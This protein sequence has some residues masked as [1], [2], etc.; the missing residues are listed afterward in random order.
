MKSDPWQWLKT[1]PGLFAAPRPEP[2]RQAERIVAVQRRIVLP[3][4]VGV[5]AVALYSVF[6]YDWLTGLPTFIWQ[7]LRGF[8]QFYVVCNAIA[9]VVFFTWR[10]F[11]PELFQCL[12]FAL[13]ILDG[14]FIAGLMLIPQGSGNVAFLLFP[15]LIVLNA[16]SIPLAMPQI[17]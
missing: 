5:V 16:I 15:I 11:P 12:V 17:V 7:A 8:F 1:F 2:L 10:R 6:S 14:L 3:V 9:A 4:K 13:G